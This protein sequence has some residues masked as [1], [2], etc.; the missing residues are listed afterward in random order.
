MSRYGYSARSSASI[1]TPRCKK[2]KLFQEVGRFLANNTQ[3]YNNNNK[4][5][6]QEKND[7]YSEYHSR[8]AAVRTA[9]PHVQRQ[10]APRTIL[11]ILPTSC[12]WNAPKHYFHAHL[13]QV[14]SSKSAGQNKT[15]QNTPIRYL[16]SKYREPKQDKYRYFP[17]SLQKMSIDTFLK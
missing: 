10:H 4:N 2:K 8:R 15:K 9:F 7:A 14:M 17:H 5:G 16:L 12:C 11:V 3:S 6:L 13:V 1:T